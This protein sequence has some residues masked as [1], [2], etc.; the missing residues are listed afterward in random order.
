M[1]GS[2]SCSSGSGAKAPRDGGMDASGGSHVSD[3]GAAGAAGSDSGADMDSDAGSDGAADADAAAGSDGV[4]GAADAISDL[5]GDGARPS[6]YEVKTPTFSVALGSETTQ[7]VVL[8]LGNEQPV[9]VGHIKATISAPIYELRIA[10]VGGGVQTTPTDCVPFGDVTDSTARPLMFAR[11]NIEDLSFPAGIVYTFAAHQLLRFEIHAWN[12]TGDALPA[13]A[14]A[15][16]SVSSDATFQ[17]E[18]GL[19][20][21][22]ASEVHVNPGETG[23]L[24][25]EFFRISDVL[26]AAS[27][28]RLEGYT[29]ELGT[30]M[31]MSLAASATDASPI[32][33]YAPNPWN[34]A[35]PLVVD[36]GVPFALGAN[37]GIALT[38]AWNN[39]AGQNPVTRG[40]SVADERCAAFVSYYPAVSAHVCVHS[41]AGTTCM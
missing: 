16:F 24:G 41:G 17:H 23:T 30:E 37:G 6:S 40:P 8:D 32:T 27:I 34:P 25:P 5:A 19:L 28:F 15:I 4:D 38:C 29:H 21:L 26:S 10:A 20:L 36:E 39:T 33:I 18:A 12:P 14:S 22:E 2:A 35:N 1:S 7:C 31:T 13:N 11:N 3:G 9:H